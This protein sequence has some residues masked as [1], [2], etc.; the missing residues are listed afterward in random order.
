MRVAV[1]KTGH[2]IADSVAASVY[3]GL[4]K[5]ECNAFPP[6]DTD[7]HLLSVEEFDIHIGYGILRGM[8]HVFRECQR[9][10]KPFIHLDKGYWKP[11]HYNG[12]YRLS[13]KGTQQTFG[14]DKIEPDYKRLDDLGVDILP[15]N[16]REKRPLICEP[17]PVVEMFFG[18]TPQDW[19]LKQCY[20]NP[21]FDDVF[22]NRPK[23]CERPL[24]QDLDRCSKVIT[25]NSSVGWEALRQGIEVVSDADYSIVGSYQKLIDSPLHQSYEQ[26]RKLF[27][28]QAGL[29]LTLD[30]VRQG[31]LWPLMQTLLSL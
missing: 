30:E 7:L 25:F 11:G 4:C 19:W 23:D 15:S 5:S 18:S 29:Q 6:L 16:D 13:L 17:T 8:D 1:W 2:E 26:R 12:Y 27:A 21:D 24:Q 14:L 28:I 3:A 10:G 9:L 20:T 22:I 31:K